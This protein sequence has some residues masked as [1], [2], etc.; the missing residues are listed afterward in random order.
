MSDL[1]NRLKVGLQMPLGQGGTVRWSEMRDIA[2]LAEDVGFDSLWVVDHFLYQL[3]AD[4]DPIGLWECWSLISALASCTNKV[5][6]GTLVL[7]MGFR[8]PAL[9]AKMADTVDEISGGRLIL[10]VGAGYHELEY[11]AFGYP[12]DKKYSRFKEAIQ[13]VH[14]LLKTGKVDFD[15]TYYS[16]RQ[17]ELKPRGPRAEG[18]PIMIGTRRPKMLKLAIQYA[19]IWNVY[20]DDTANSPAGAARMR[21]LVD[22]ACAEGG[23]DPATLERTVTVLTAEEGATPWWNDMPFDDDFNVTPAMGTPEQIAEELMAYRRE[24]ISHVQMNMDGLTPKVVEKFG[25]VLEILKA[26][27]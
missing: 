10:G 15:G 18:P 13:I 21:E 17:C 16:A 1:Q 7:G 14:S 24:G 6:L 19:D 11:T 25:R 12:Y 22:A 26:Q 4:S 9:L 2:T 20:W 5:E 27:G 23:R 3:E 8:N